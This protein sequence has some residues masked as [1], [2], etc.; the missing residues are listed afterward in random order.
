MS[1]IEA[2]IA[3]TE[4]R[5][6]RHLF[7][8]K[9]KK[10]PEG[11]FVSLFTLHTLVR[12]ATIEEAM[13]PKPGHS[14]F[15][16][17]GATYVYDGGLGELIMADAHADTFCDRVLCNA[18]AAMLE[19]TGGITDNRLRAYVCGRLSGWLVT[20]SKRKR[21][22]TRDNWGRDAVI[23]GRLVLPLL[24]RFKATRNDATEAESACSIAKAALE[25]IGI[26]ISEKRIE[27][28]WG[29]Y[30]SRSG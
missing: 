5:A 11:Y 27:E 28:I 22:R 21:G 20:N 17:S 19:A 10:R 16:W 8:S 15:D 2:A 9:G 23:V 30:R 1:D 12:P 18:A 14:L 3:E 13:Q 24:D 29:K 26:H 4:E 25:R 6:R 7:D